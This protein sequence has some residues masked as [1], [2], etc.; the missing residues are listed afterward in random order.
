MPRVFLLIL[1]SEHDVSGKV[2]EH[3]MVKLGDGV[4]KVGEGL[5][6]GFV[7]EAGDQIESVGVGHGLGGGWWGC[8]PFVLSVWPLGGRGA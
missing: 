8:S 6:D 2:A 5:G 7:G 1:S 3:A 4:A